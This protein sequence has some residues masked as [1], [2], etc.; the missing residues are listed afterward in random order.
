MI[1]SSSLIPPSSPPP[2]QTSGRKGGGLTTVQG[3]GVQMPGTSRPVYACTGETGSPARLF[4]RHAYSTRRSPSLRA[5][6]PQ[7]RTPPYRLRSRKSGDDGHR[8]RIEKSLSKSDHGRSSSNI[9]EK[10]FKFI[11]FVAQ[12]EKI[13]ND[14][15]RKISFQDWFF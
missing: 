2:R 11:I 6:S 7:F 9:P 10:K 8:V 15:S 1:S 5:R 13:T 4:S 12:R 14:S 3:H